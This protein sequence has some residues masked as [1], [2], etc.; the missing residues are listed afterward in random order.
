MG[1]YLWTGL[2]VDLYDFSLNPRAYPGPPQVLFFFR[3][4]CVAP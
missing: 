3:W 4:C 2:C 1:I